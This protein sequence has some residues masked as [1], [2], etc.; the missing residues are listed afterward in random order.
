MI[1]PIIAR[2]RLAQQRL[3]ANAFERP[4][5][6]VTWMGAVQ[7]QDY[8]GGKWALGLRMNQP[9][10]SADALIE[11]AFNE[12]RILRTHIMRPTWHFVTPADIRWIMALNGSRL[13]GMNPAM[14][15][16]LD[17]DANVF[18]RSNDVFA[19]ALEGGQFLTRAQLGKKL[20]E[21]GITAGGLRLAFM[22]GRAE[23]DLVV[24]SGPRRGKQFTY[25]LLDEC[26]PQGLVFQHD[27][28]IAELTRRYFASHGPATL[29]DFAWWSGLTLADAKAG[30]EMLAVTLHTEVI[31]GQTYW[32]SA[33]CGANIAPENTAFLLPTFDEYFVGYA[34]FDKMRRGGPNAKGKLVFES[35]IIIDGQVVGS[36]RQTVKNNEVLI[37]LAPFEP[38]T[39]AEHAAIDA[40]VQ[41]L[42]TFL[43]TVVRCTPL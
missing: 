29:R 17:L 8:P 22:T 40:A 21:A 35:T 1:P 37:E 33:E 27:E 3:S 36:W 28:A 13:K 19:K 18:A 7:A 25:A 6:V 23:L 5:E 12:G 2:Q 43:G 38:L 24:C 34:N 9:D 42:S 41:R 30:V 26:A 11:K 14:L 10:E 4:E 39:S 16:S 20:A 15:R 31:E 32:S